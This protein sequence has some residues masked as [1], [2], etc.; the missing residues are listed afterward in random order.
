MPI[1]FD[2]GRPN[3]ISPAHRCEYFI[4]GTYGNQKLK[5]QATGAPDAEKL[6]WF[7]NGK[8]YTSTSI[9]D[10]ILWDME[11]GRH[12]ITCSDS[13]GRSSSVIVTVR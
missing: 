8:F 12:K 7:V 11:L 1:D 5:L 13:F 3:I 9:G 6:Y 10:K 2:R 4:S